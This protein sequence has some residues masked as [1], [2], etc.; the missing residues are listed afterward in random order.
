[1]LGPED[2]A[3]VALAAGAD[4][5]ASDAELDF[6]PSLEGPFEESVLP[7]P[8]LEAPSFDPLSAVFGAPDDLD[9]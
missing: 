8:E 7:S 2:G 4:V 5:E 9:G 6:P 1:L 3:G